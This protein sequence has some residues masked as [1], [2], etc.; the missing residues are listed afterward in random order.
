[1]VGGVARLRAKRF[2]ASLDRRSQAAA[3]SHTQTFKG[4]AVFP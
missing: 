4:V 3:H 2:A 1:V